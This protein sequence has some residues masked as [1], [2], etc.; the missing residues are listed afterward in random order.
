MRFETAPPPDRPNRPLL[1]VALV[2]GAV[3]TLV[4]ICSGCLGGLLATAL[5]GEARPVPAEH[6]VVAE[7]VGPAAGSD[8]AEGDAEWP[9]EEAPDADEAAIADAEPAPYDSDIRAELGGDSRTTAR[10]HRFQLPDDAVYVEITLDAG[11]HDLDLDAGFGAP[12]DGEWEESSTGD[13]GRESIWFARSGRSEFVRLPLHV[14]VREYDDT[15][16]EAPSPYTLH[17]RVVRRSVASVLRPGESARGEL[18]LADG[19][20][21]TYTLVLPAGV[22]RVRVDLSDVRQDL[23]LHA[24]VEP[25]LDL[26]DADCEAD[27]YAARECLIVD[28]DELELPPGEQRLDLVVANPEFADRR[29]PFRVTVTAG[30]EPP[31][32][33]RGLP[34]LPQDGS[35]AERAARAVVALRTPDG[36]GSGVLVAERGVILTAAHVVEDVADGTD[37]ALVALCVDPQV[38]P[39]ECLR[40][41]VVAR[42]TDLDVAVLEVTSDSLGLPLEGPVRL[43]TLP[44]RSR[45]PQL[46]ESVAAVGYPA[47]HEGDEHEEITWTAGLVSGFENTDGVP[48]VRFDAEIAAGSSGGALLDAELRL[49]A[50][51]VATH[52]DTSHFSTTG[53][54]VPIGA[55]PPDWSAFWR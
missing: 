31:Q 33:L 46:A 19:D 54:A 26:D 45:A 29:M 42:D 55:L 6:V 21:A 35:P 43:P 11:L 20:R 12:A 37:D 27:T 17:A 38:E 24:S 14:R 44:L 39:Y 47:L 7:P 2:A 28:R 10:V 52:E 32:E 5:E 4:G 18:L 49:L 40:A 23:S 41:R 8:A 30:I 34:T 3:A 9:D 15:L 1:V 22:D 48:L 51:T 36:T 53:L 50:I 16:H 13:D 25:L